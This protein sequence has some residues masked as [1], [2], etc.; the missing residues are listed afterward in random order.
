MWSVVV[1]IDSCNTVIIKFYERSVVMA[2]TSG[3]RQNLMDNKIN[4]YQAKAPMYQIRLQ[5]FMYILE[6]KQD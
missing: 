1:F 5:Y 6:V 3:L 2:S 4:D